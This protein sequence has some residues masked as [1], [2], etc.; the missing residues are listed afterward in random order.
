LLTNT[1]PSYVSH[2]GFPAKRW[3]C[4][5]FIQLGPGVV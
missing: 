1:V 3:I 2:F 5:F 4:S